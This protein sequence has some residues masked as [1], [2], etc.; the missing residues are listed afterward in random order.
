MIKLPVQRVS[1]DMTPPGIPNQIPESRSW[2]VHR[3]LLPGPP[4]KETC[5][6][7]QD[8]DS[9][10]DSGFLNPREGSSARAVLGG[11]GVPARGLDFR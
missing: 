10:S 1:G 3:A 11:P 4:K 7:S 6:Q 2:I 8:R 9:E 5:A